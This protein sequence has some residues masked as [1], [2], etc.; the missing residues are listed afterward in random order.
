[1][2]TNKKTS[3]YFDTSVFGGYYDD[4]FERDT[5]FLF[6]KIKENKYDIFIS[7]LTKKELERAPEEVRN[8]LNDIQYQ[9]IEVSQECRDL[10][11]EYIKEDVVGATSKDDCIHIAT[12]TISKIDMLVSWNFKHIVNIQRIK[13]YNLI[14]FKNGHGQLLICSPKD[15]VLYE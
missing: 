3:L 11:E 14:N 13:G 1:M 12:A 8:L 15:A 6:S 4:V 2:E 10:A 5:R 7:D 9:L